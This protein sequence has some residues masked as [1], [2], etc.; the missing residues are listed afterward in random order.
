MKLQNLDARKLHPFT[1]I[2]LIIKNYP[3]FEVTIA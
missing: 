1:Q 2:M 3:H